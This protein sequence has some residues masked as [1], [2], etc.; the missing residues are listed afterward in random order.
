MKLKCKKCG[1]EDDFYIREKFFGVT[2]LC[3][4]ADGE[5]TDNADVYDNAEYRLKSVYYYC[6]KCEAKVAKIPEEKRY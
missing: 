3:V 5:L 1:N 4:D 6:R 2:E